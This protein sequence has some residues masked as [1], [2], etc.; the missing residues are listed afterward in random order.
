[1]K[2]KISIFGTVS[3]S[4]YNEVVERAHR[5]WSLMEDR[6]GGVLVQNITGGGRLGNRTL[7]ASQN[8]SLTNPRVWAPYSRDALWEESW[9]TGGRWGKRRALSSSSMGQQCNPFPLPH[10][11]SC[12][13]I[14]SA[15]YDI[16]KSNQYCVRWWSTDE[17]HLNKTNSFPP[18]MSVTYYSQTVNTNR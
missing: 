3:L 10:T 6:V 7:S 17:A 1:M 4:F 14:P 11:R 5:D 2:Y 15:L 8:G 16:F 13:G 18:R 9:T 12:L